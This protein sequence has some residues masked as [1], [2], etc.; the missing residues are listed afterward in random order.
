MTL[1]YD[2][3]VISKDV[4]AG[5]ICFLKSI[6]NMKSEKNSQFEAMSGVKKEGGN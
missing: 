2:F 5:V 3:Y 1:E 4:N 6:I